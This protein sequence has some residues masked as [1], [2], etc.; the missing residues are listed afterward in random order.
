MARA[1]LPP[2]S[3]VARSGLRTA[4]IG[5]TLEIAAEDALEVEVA[6]DDPAYEGARVE[7]VWRGETVDRAT[8]TA[9]GTAR[10]RRWPAAG[11]YL[12]VHVTAA[13]GAPLAITNPVF[14]TAGR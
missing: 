6:V 1:T 10:F 13:D 12:R 8:L 2:P 9:R 14:V 3:V 11:G 7:L 4:T 5:E